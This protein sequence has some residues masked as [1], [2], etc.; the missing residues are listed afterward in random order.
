MFNRW[1]SLRQYLFYRLVLRHP[2]F[3]LWLTRLVA[4][5]RELEVSFLGDLFRVHSISEFGL[6]RAARLA[7][8]SSVLRD[9]LPVLL[10]LATL[11]RNEDVFIDVGANVGLYS[12][13]FSRLQTFH[14]R[15]RVVAFEPHSGTFE[16]L[17]ENLRTTNAQV[18]CIALSGS[19]GRLQ[20]FEGAASA[21]FS[22]ERSPF[23]LANRAIWIETKR[24]D[25]VSLPD[26]PIVLKIDVEGHEFEVLRGATG[27]FEQK[28]IAVVFLDGF[29]EP[30]IPRFLEDL[31]FSL[32]DAS[33][34]QP[35][36]EGHRQLLAIQ[37]QRI[38]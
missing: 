17:K 32:F 30:S 16:R 29:G 35:F 10:N 4:G 37:P 6:V 8:S 25:E 11:I 31:G 5:D 1:R 34:L 14:P 18:H 23:A 33:T 15:L 36:G 7:E 2:R 38:G 28:R 12:K 20:F 26:G 22:A 3:R 19:T 24:L 13:L 9:E 27:L 21:V